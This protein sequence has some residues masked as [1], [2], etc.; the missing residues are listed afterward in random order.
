MTAIKY[1]TGGFIGVSSLLADPRYNIKDKVNEVKGR[2]NFRPFAP[3][4][5]EEDV[6][7]Y[8]NDGWPSPYM[9]CACTANEEFKRKYPGVVHLDGTSRLQVIKDG[10]HRALLQIWKDI[11]K[12]PVI[13]NT[14]LNVKG[15]P[16]VNTRKDAERFIEKT[17]VQV[18]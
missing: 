9:S 11:T 6:I 5:L 8:F 1:N 13:L 3:M 16:I 7:K 18:F 17:G 14:S 15:E 4:I 10:P 12:C 2:E